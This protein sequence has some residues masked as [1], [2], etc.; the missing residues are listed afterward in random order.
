MDA[1]DFREEYRTLAQRAAQWFRDYLADEPKES[2]Y[3]W[4][5]DFDSLGV[6]E[7]VAPH[8]EHERESLRQ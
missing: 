7:L 1:E 8:L 5:R 6:R 3:D 4:L 2:C